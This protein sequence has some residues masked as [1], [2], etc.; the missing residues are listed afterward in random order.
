[1]TFVVGDKPDDYAWVDILGATVAAGS[2]RLFSVI[3][4]EQLDAEVRK[5]LFV[6]I[7]LKFQKFVCQGVGI[8]TIFLFGNMKQ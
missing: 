4:K 5:K 7:L 6:V 1:M 8:G 2:R 3:S